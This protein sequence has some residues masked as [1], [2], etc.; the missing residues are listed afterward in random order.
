MNL[1]WDNF[2]NWIQRIDSIIG[3]SIGLITIIVFFITIIKKRLRNGLS[4][5]VGEWHHYQLTIKDTSK[6]LVH[7]LW[8]FSL[9]WYSPK[10]LKIKGRNADNKSIQYEGTVTLEGDKYYTYCKSKHFGENV[11]MIID[12]PYD[13][14][15]KVFGIATSISYDKD[16][17]SH[18]FF[19]SKEELNEQQREEIKKHLEILYLD[20]VSINEII[21]KINAQI[22]TN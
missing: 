3:V 7:Y 13:N 16:L 21:E 4:H 10:I 17:I 20:K 8:K 18:L 11:F 14:S 19:L 22:K 9:V 15:V 6:Q 2:F 12:K 1:F 5:M